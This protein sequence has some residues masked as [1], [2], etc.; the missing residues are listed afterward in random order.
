MSTAKKTETPIDEAQ[1]LAAELNSDIKHEYIDGN[2]YAMS[3][4][5]KNHRTLCGNIFSLL[6]N[7][8]KDKPCKPSWDAR[9]KAAANYF[10]PDI[11]VDC[12]EQST[13]DSLYAQQPKI[14]VEVLSRTTRHMDRGAKLLSYINIPS[15]QEYVLVEQEF[16]SIDVLRRSDGW[17]SRHY[18]L[19]ESIYFESIDLHVSVDAIY[20]SV[21]N[22]DVTEF[23]AK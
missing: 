18:T 2:V 12:D 9:V 15:L 5:S 17:V 1:Y 11:V 16:A 21:D 4:A 3:G 10:Y 19:G 7:Y 20:H 23:L 6:H 13:A 8:L 22:E 14:I